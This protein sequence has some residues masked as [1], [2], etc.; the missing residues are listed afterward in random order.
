M[1]K[2]AS[3]FPD[4]PFPVDN[5][6]IPSQCLHGSCSD[7]LHVYLHYCVEF[8]AAPKGTTG[9]FE[10]LSSHTKRSFRLRP[11]KDLIYFE[12]RRP[13]AVTPVVRA[14]VRVMM[15]GAHIRSLEGRSQLSGTEDLIRLWL[16]SAVRR[17]P[18][19]AQVGRIVSRRL[20]NSIQGSLAPFLER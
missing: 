16:G 4:S 10:P 14:G 18:V 12:T 7:Q 11:V 19:K 1:Y 20:A 17:R 8:R 3:V 13:S 2:T 9:V 5:K 6:S 15:Q